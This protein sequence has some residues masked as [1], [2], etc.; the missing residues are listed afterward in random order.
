MTPTGP[1]TRL[2][3][4]SAPHDHLVDDTGDGAAPRVTALLEAARAL[5]AAASEGDVLAA[6]ALEGARAM[7]ATAAAL[8]LPDPERRVV[9]TLVATTREA[10]RGAAGDRAVR[11]DVTDLPE[12]HPLPVVRAALTGEAWFLPDRA[13]ALDALP[14]A[15]ELY[16]T[17]STEA[18]VVL[19]LLVGD[20]CAG[21]LGLA[22]DEPRDWL[23]ADREL[24]EALAALTGQ[25]LDRLAALEA[26][27]AAVAELHRVA[28]ALR[29]SLAPSLSTTALPGLD[30]VAVS[31][32]AAQDVRL[33]GDWADALTDDDAVV[34]AVGD[35]VGHDGVTAVAVAQARG[36]LRG[37]LRALG[38]TSPAALLAALDEVLSEPDTA[39]MATAVVC[40]A[41]RGPGPA[42][43]WQ[44]RCA[45]AGH[46]PPLLRH[47]DGRV[48][49]V[50]P[51]GDLLLGLADGSAG[52]TDVRRAEH[53][54]EALPGSVL[55]V[56]SD[57]VVERRGEGLA[58]RHAAL[59]ELLAGCDTSSAGA[60]CDA[61]LEAVGAGAEDDVTV[62]VAV[63]G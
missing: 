50:G 17:S 3:A 13:A 25:A 38:S 39:V 11:V 46:L 58:D 61:V 63:L 59:A 32:P 60:V 31:L 4:P 2:P 8:C 19:P 40:R 41:S 56:F 18:S 9:R 20:R 14:Q 47:P 7:G 45:S 49:A 21:A 22:F 10:A 43:T 28:D 53:V 48:E 33:G 5:G 24:V 30:V 35:V 26:E 34:L 44:L 15:R 42:G 55:L 29:D 52:I 57:G 12:Q 37:A 27:R 16:E 23:R 54:L 51:V 1:S 6:V 62:L 36:G